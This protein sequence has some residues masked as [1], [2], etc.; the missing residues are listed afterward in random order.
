MELLEIA[1]TLDLKLFDSMSS[2]VRV[3]EFEMD[4]SAE[5]EQKA[6]N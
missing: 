6:A 4:F 3:L 5:L 1:Q 2:T